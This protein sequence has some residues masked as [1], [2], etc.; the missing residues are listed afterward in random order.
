MTVLEGSP[1]SLGGTPPPPR[2]PPGIPGPGPA[3]QRPPVATRT[4]AGWQG[5]GGFLR[6]QTDT[7]FTLTKRVWVLLSFLEPRTCLNAVI[8]QMFAKLIVYLSQQLMV[9]ILPKTRSARPHRRRVRC[10][11]RFAAPRGSRPRVEN[12]L[13]K[14]SQHGHPFTIHHK[15]AFLRH[16][17]KSLYLL[18]QLS[19]VGPAWYGQGD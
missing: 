4:F 18:R 15:L 12:P 13:R 7:H 10:G 16:S 1:A 6:D 14:G 8:V 5:R 19:S 3:L 11:V 17:P 9:P 2:S